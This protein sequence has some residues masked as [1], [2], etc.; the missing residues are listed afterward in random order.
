MEKAKASNHLVDMNISKLHAKLIAAGRLNPPDDRVPY[1]FEKRVMT[2]LQTRAVED[3]WTLWGKALWRSAFA[4]MA[5]AVA[6]SIWS[7]QA[8]GEAEYDL[9]STMV[10]PAEQLVDTW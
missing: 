1:T 3:V 7:W 8:N 5:V 9:E 10:A 2:Q 6:L 4:C